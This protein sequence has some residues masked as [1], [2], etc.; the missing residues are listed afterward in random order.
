LK[1]TNG[2]R[3]NGAGLYSE[4]PLILEDG[5]ELCLGKLVFRVYFGS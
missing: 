2:S 1:S 3:V 5:D 4:I